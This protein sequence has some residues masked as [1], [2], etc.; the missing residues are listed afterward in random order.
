ME[1]VVDCM[2]GKLA[3]WLR[4]LGFKAHFFNKIGDSQLLSKAQSLGAILLTRDTHLISRS[5]GVKTL[6]IES[7]K[8][9]DQV[10]QVLDEFQLWDDIHPYSRCIECNAE[11]KRLTKT[12]AKNLVAPFVYESAETFALCL[13]C[14]RV[15]WQ[16]THIKDM[17]FKIREIL[18][19]KG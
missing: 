9:R 4:I 8:W 10:A 16:G 15:F 19:K 2:L 17:E 13:A 3:K 1:F 6:L 5:H 7:E 11:L 18:K 12:Q 14:G